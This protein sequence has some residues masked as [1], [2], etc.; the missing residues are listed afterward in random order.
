MRRMEDRKETFIGTALFQILANTCDLGIAIP[1]LWMRVFNFKDKLPRVYP[2]LRQ[3]SQDLNPK[4]YP[5][6]QLRSVPSSTSC[7]WSSQLRL[8]PAAPLPAPTR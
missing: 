4:K 3:Q 1:A 7:L 6:F 2:A 5:H 8:S